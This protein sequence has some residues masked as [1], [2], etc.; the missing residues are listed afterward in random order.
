MASLREGRNNSER[1]QKLLNQRTCRLKI[2]KSSYLRI[3]EEHFF[4]SQQCNTAKQC[5]ECLAKCQ[6]NGHEDGKSNHWI[7]K[8]ERQSH[9]DLPIFN[10]KDDDLC[11]VHETK[12]AEPHPWGEFALNPKYNNCKDLDKYHPKSNKG[13]TPPATDFH[14]V[15]FNQFN[16]NLVGIVPDLTTT[17]GD[18]KTCEIC[19]IH[20]IP[21][22]LIQ[23]TYPN[24]VDQANFKEK[25]LANPCEVKNQFWELSYDQYSGSLP[26]TMDT[27][28][29]G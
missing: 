17:I 6:A 4:W 20:T 1:L 24:T 16:L 9:S 19:G 10:L 12:G 14:T 11:P 28:T 13:E 8:K 5:A 27:T 26:F 3:K 22:A 21:T 15:E 25:L 7:K 18:G 2:A 29:I 23:L